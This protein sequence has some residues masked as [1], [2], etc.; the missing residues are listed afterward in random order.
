MHAAAAIGK[1]LD[2]HVR[3]RE[4]VHGLCRIR[5]RRDSANSIKL[6]VAVISSFQTKTRVRF[7]QARH[8]N[9]Q[10]HE[11]LI[12]VRRTS[13]ICQFH[14]EQGLSPNIVCSRKLILLVY[15]QQ[16]PR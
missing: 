12:G 8:R 14:A 13:C 7:R 15:G 10:L 4:R 16:R 1:G 9:D 11:N 3:A 6:L 2:R 5:L